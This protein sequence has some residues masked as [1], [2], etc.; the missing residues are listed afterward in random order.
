MFC[1]YCGKE[2]PDS[3]IFCSQCGKK[4]NYQK[5]IEENADTLFQQACE[6]ARNNEFEKSIPLFEQADKLGHEEASA[7]LAN[8]YIQGHGVDIDYDRGLPYLEKSVNLGHPYSINLLGTLYSEGRGVKKDLEQ[9]FIS[10]SIAAENG[11]PY[12]FLNLAECYELGE[13]TE[14]NIDE[15][16]NCYYYLIDNAY[17]ED[18]KKEAFHALEKYQTNPKAIYYL[19]KQYNGLAINNSVPNP[20]KGAQ[21]ILKAAELGYTDAQYEIGKLYEVGLGVEKNADKAKEWIERAAKQGSEGAIYTLQYMTN[22]NFFDH[23]KTVVNK[24]KYRY[25]GKVLFRKYL[26]LEV[27]KD[28]VAQ[29]PEATL[30]SLNETFTVHNKWGFDF[31]FFYSYDDVIVKQKEYNYYFDEPIKLENG[32]VIAVKICSDF[33]IVNGFKDIATRYGFNI[34]EVK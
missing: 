7:W 4:L 34:E 32:E 8:I 15:A 29:H 9:A 3:A 20:E 21:L 26:A 33:T 30:K 14:K 5:N 6:F 17:D 31:E 11:E 16:L 23:G 12:A 2:L 1:K 13:G 22:P 25:K 18:I 19:S 28:F 27:I 10:F 24:T